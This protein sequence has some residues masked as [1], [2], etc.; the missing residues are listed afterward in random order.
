MG[1]HFEHIKGDLFKSFI[2]FKWFVD[3][4]CNRYGI[5]VVYIEG[6]SGYCLTYTYEVLRISTRIVSNFRKEDMSI[7][8]SS[9]RYISDCLDER[10]IS[11]K[12]E[13]NVGTWEIIQFR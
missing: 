1:E 8:W 4:M 11:L 3:K 6:V 5:W 13:I 12:R 7:F 9:E 2:L 10:L